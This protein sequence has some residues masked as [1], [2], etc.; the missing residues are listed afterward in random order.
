MKSSII[1]MSVA[2]L[3]AFGVANAATTAAAPAA[4]SPAATP[5]AAPAKA[6]TD[7]QQKMSD[8]A[9]ANKGKK[10]DDYKNSVS[11]CMKA[12]A[13]TPAAAATPAP[14]PAPATT[15]PTATK[16][17]GAQQQK[18][19]DCAKANKGKKGDDYKSSMSACMKK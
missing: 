9:K 14:P 19:A 6:K 10:G 2:A 3:L 8:C 7:Q 17:K 11:N 18:M 16:S 12:P 1:A 15:P 5:A 4:A 13:A